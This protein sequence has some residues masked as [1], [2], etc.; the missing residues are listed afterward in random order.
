M[1]CGAEG[2]RRITGLAAEGNRM[3][4]VHVFVS[5]GRFRSFAEMRAF[6]EQTYTDD[7]FGIPSVFER[8]VAQ[9]WYEPG[10]IEC[11]HRTTPIPVPE[12]LAGASYADQWLPA[13][14]ISEVADAAIC[15]FSPNVVDHP[16]DSSLRYL[17]AFG[18]Q[19]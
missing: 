9:S 16:E 4:A 15:V 17:G 19:P 13:L 8:E 7:G 11:T 6:V 3:D 1:H 12:L 5:T 18:Y 14:K 2:V 10:C